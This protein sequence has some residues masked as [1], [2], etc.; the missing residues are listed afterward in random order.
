MQTTA[1][2]PEVLD[3]LLRGIAHQAWA[4][5]PDLYAEDAVVEQPFAIPRPVRLVGRE[6]IRAHFAAAARAPLALEVRN[7][8]V[9][10]TA[11]PDVL[12]AEFDYDGRATSG[13]AFTV[14]NVQVLTVRAGQIVR[15]RDYHNHHALAEALA[16]DRQRD[17]VELNPAAV[18]RGGVRTGD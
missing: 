15:S 3:R 14:A 16:A 13:G 8:V 9:H 6:Q 18:S 7:L 1:T 4:E 12:V 11:N 5:L 17:S 2:A 10:H